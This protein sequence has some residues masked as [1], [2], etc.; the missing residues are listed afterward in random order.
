MLACEHSLESS[1]R[2]LSDSLRGFLNF[3][4]LL[5]VMKQFVNFFVRGGFFNGLLNRLN[6]VR[7]RLASSRQKALDELYRTVCGDF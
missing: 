1:R 7:S 4:L 2:A 5:I 3:L 6:V